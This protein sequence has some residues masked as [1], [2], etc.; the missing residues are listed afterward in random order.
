M[1]PK[2]NLNC[3]GHPFPDCICK[4]GLLSNGYGP[5]L[6][7]ILKEEKLHRLI[8]AN[9]CSGASLVT[10]DRAIFSAKQQFIGWQKKSVKFDGIKLLLK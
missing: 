3:F 7:K 8:P 10:Y 4:C 2:L 9:I 5:L 6:F 1:F